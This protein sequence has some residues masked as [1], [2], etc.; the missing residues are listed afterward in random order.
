MML[1]IVCCGSLRQSILQ[2]M[3]ELEQKHVLQKMKCGSKFLSSR[4]SLRLFLVFFVFAVC[5]NA[6]VA[7]EFQPASV[8]VLNLTFVRPRTCKWESPAP[9]RTSSTLRAESFKGAEQV[10]LH[11]GQLQHVV[12]VPG[13]AAPD[14]RIL[15]NTVLAVSDCFHHGSN[16]V[17]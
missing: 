5:L 12:G 9:A 4:L 2:A 1:L 8:M 17:F 10:G 16:I 7:E 11:R 14:R 13:V 3:V 15:E 6:L